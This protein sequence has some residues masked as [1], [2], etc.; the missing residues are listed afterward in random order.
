MLVAIFGCLVI[1][2][3]AVVMCVVLVIWDP[4]ARSVFWWLWT[5]LVFGLAVDVLYCVYA[6][7]G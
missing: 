6:S 4:W 3:I 7:R 5:F 1:C 2:A